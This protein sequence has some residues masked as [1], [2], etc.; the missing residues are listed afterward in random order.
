MST[1]QNL[2]LHQLLLDS[3]DHKYH[4]LI[5]WKVPSQSF[6]NQSIIIDLAGDISGIPSNLT[7]TTSSQQQCFTVSYI[8]DNIYENTESGRLTVDVSGTGLGTGTP[9]STTLRIVDNNSK[10]ISN[11]IFITSNL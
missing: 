3:P 5:Q 11:E 2:L 4:L 10:Y 8:D 7:F 1:S 6:F 9:S